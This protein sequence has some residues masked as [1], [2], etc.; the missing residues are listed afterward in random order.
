MFDAVILAGGGEPEP[1]TEQEKVSN[2]AFIMLYG[3]PL[4]SYI[5]EALEET[6]SIERIVA[7]GPVGELEKLHEEGYGFE[8]VAEEGGMLDNLA[9]GFGLV[10]HNRLCLVVTGDIPL[11]TAEITE[12]FISLCSPHDRDFYFPILSREDCVEKFPAAERTYVHL[13]EGPVTGGN[14]ALLN[15][16]WFLENRAR[17]EMFIS[18]RKK[19]LK[20]LRIL[21]FT[22]IFKYLRRRLSLSDLEAFIS[23]LLK[24]KVRAVPCDCVEIGLDVDKPSD[25]EVVKKTI[26]GGYY[27]QT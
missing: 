24:L 22:L 20:L 4:L 21:P 1:L 3:R 27:D 16:R 11:L 15:P 23:R 8:A 10:N 12:Y 18:Y 5:L 19:P 14:I 9:A 25:L 7:V 26:E 17:L 13:N 6:P 2:K